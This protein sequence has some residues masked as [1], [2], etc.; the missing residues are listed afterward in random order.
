MN[1]KVKWTVLLGFV[2]SLLA[3]TIMALLTDGSAV[4]VAAWAIFFELLQ[5]P[6]MACSGRDRGPRT[7]DRGLL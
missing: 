7:Q 3:A 4:S 6:V 2:A 1:P 5:L